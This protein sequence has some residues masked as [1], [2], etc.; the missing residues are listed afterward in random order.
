MTEKDLVLIDGSYFCF[1][2]YHATVQW[3]RLARPGI[4]LGV[5]SENAEFVERFCSTFVTSLQTFLK[6]E[7]L[8]KP[9]LWVG[10]DYPNVWRNSVICAYKGTR[11]N[12]K[13][14]DIGFFLNLAYNSLFAAAG[15][16]QVLGMAELEADD[17]IALAVCELYK[18]E[19][20]PDIVIITSDHDYLQLNRPGVSLVNLKHQRLNESKKSHN[21]A[22]LDLFCKILCGDKSDNIPGVVPGVG[23]KTAVKLFHDPNKLA[24]LLDKHP[25]AQGRFTMNRMLIDFS[26][27]PEHLA[28]Q[29]RTTVLDPALQDL[30]QTLTC[31]IG[32][33]TSHIPRS[34]LE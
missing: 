26:N 32:G 27:I 21:D 14:K 33:P 6:K 17:C 19:N 25:G 28:E 11:D 10:K 30:P 8:T 34:I 9:T 12:S 2:R 31:A 7:H 5:P 24:A 20:R 18:C 1:Y 23:P 16:S 3:W 13:H 15:V 29:F 22:D 4:E